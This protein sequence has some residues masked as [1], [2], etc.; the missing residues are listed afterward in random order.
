MW[1]GA[2]VCACMNHTDIM[3]HV[4]LHNKQNVSQLL[5]PQHT[6]LFKQGTKKN[7][8]L[9]IWPKKRSWNATTKCFSEKEL[10][11]L[12]PS[13]SKHKG[14]QKIPCQ[15]THT[16]NFKIHNPGRSRMWRHF[17]SVQNVINNFNFFYRLRAR[18]PSAEYLPFSL[19]LVVILSG[20]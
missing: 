17:L 10:H 15:H 14:V 19:L 1:T 9:T 3:I 6:W 7:F 11:I 2:G 5:F 12:Q 20:D 16:F 13:I 18:F 4:L 8:G